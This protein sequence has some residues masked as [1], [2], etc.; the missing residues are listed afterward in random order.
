MMQCYMDAI[1]EQ[2]NHGFLIVDNRKSFG[3]GRI[4]SVD[5][6]Q[7]DVQNGNT[8]STIQ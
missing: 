6:K 7:Y 1:T 2:N 8:I 3:E 5:G 4:T